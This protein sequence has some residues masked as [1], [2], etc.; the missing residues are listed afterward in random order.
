MNISEWHI[1]ILY[2][3]LIQINQINK[4]CSYISN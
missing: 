2:L 3:I 4:R 1:D